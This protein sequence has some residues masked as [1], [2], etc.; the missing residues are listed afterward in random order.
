MLQLITTM[1]ITMNHTITTVKQSHHRRRSSCNTCNIFDITSLYGSEILHN[2]LPYNI[3]STDIINI[4]RQYVVSLLEC[5]QCGKLCCNND[6][7]TS[8][9]CNYTVC[10]LCID[11]QSII[12]CKHCNKTQ[13]LNTNCCKPNYIYTCIACDST[14]CNKCI[15]FNNNVQ[16]LDN[17][18]I[19]LCDAVPKHYEIM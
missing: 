16:Q 2:I 6:S 5:N 7:T 1:Y 13:C 17:T 15:G 11:K 12:S 18:T 3:I 9:C 4:I 10:Y 8:S 19:C 14:I